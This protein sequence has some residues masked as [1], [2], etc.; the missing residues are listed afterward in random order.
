MNGHTDGGSVKDQKKKKSK[1]FEATDKVVEKGGY[2]NAKESMNGAIEHK[3]KGKIE[4]NGDCGGHLEVKVSGM[5]SDD[6]KFR[7]IQLFSEL[8]VSKEVLEC[9]KGFKKPSP[10]Q[11][12]A[13]PF[14]LD[15]RNLIGIAATGSGNLAAQ[16]FLFNLIVN[17]D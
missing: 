10:I 7:P 17:I 6:S 1:T 3:K 2:V 14:L 13:W 5:G 15:D 16:I 12:H 8:H 4:A 11:S 9:C